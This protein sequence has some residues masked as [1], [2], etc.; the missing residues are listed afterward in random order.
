MVINWVESDSVCNNTSD[1]EIGQPRGGIH[2]FYHKYGTDQHWTTSP[3][4]NNHKHYNFQLQASD[5]VEVS[6]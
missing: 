3:V 4:T 2:F 5:Y 6:N 1:Y